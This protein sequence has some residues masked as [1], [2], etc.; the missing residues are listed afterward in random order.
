MKKLSTQL[1]TAIFLG[2]LPGHP[3]AD[4]VSELM[5]THWRGHHYTIVHRVT[6]RVNRCGVCTGQHQTAWGM[7]EV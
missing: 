2:T 1:T 3:E 7:V 4:A 6:S 5:T